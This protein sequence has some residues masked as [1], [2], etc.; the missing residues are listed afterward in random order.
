MRLVF[1]LKRSIKFDHFVLKSVDES[2]YRYVI[3]FFKT[4]DEEKS[5]KSADRPL[6]GQWPK[7]KIW[8]FLENFF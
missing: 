7:M 3:D 1:D 6:A 2:K 5:E 8:I 4:A